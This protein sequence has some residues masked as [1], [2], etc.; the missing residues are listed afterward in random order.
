MPWLGEKWPHTQ[1]AHLSVF[2]SLLLRNIL[3]NM[4]VLEVNH[5]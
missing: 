5:D 3:G 2:M 1:A 4:N